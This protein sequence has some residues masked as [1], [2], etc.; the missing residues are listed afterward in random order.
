MSVVSY[1][2]AAAPAATLIAALE[3]PASTQS[4][5]P[6]VTTPA[7]AMVTQGPSDA[8]SIHDKSDQGPPGALEGIYVAVVTGGGNA[9]FR[10]L[11]FNPDGWVVKDIP[12]EGM[13]G[14]D[15]TSYRNDRNTNKNWVGRYRL[16]EDKIYIDWQ[17]SR[18]PGYPTSRRWPSMMKSLRIPPG[19]PARTPSYP[20]AAVRARGFPANTNGD[21]PIRTSICSSSLMVRSLISASQTS[22]WRSAS[23]A[24]ESSGVPTRSKARP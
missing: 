20:R 18:G 3:K 15:F 4:S 19:N 12:P 22:F 14:F 13:I 21:L 17:D 23:I 6:L 24:H 5:P 2:N 1:G 11:N 10:R 7:E 8:T 9:S 16:D